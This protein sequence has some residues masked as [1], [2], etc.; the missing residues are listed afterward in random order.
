MIVLLPAETGR[1]PVDNPDTHLELTMLHEG[2]LL[3][4][5]GPGLACMVLA[6]HTRQ[7]V[8]LGLVSSLFFPVGLAVGAGAT[9]LLFGVTA[10]VVKVA[11]LAT[12]L[13]LVES[14]YAKLRLFRV[15]QY[16]GVGFVCALTALALRIL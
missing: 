6:S 2:M 5:S 12:Y 7:I 3:E 16:L 14:S 11:L 9:A 10:F 1:I 8:T 15:P 4:H 13:A